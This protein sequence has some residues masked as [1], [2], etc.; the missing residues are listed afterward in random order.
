MFRHPR[1]RR[2][3]ILYNVD[4]LRLMPF[5]LSFGPAIFKA[6]YGDSPFFIRGE[7]VLSIKSSSSSV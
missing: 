5:F 4:L 7:M 6:A 1:S 2:S 3:I